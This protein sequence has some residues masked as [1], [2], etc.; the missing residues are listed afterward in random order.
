MCART[1]RGGGARA[2]VRMLRLSS[3]F[4]LRTALWRVGEQ[5]L[6]GALQHLS[7]RPLS[8]RNLP[9]L[10]PWRLGWERNACTTFTLAVLCAGDAVGA[11]FSP[12][13]CGGVTRDEEQDVLRS[14]CCHIGVAASSSCFQVLMHL[15]LRGSVMLMDAREQ[16]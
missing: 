9:W 11:F 13:L 6:G 5:V 14:L 4:I 10:G 3:A 7:S 1:L 2:G 15:V 8:S 16:S 12:C